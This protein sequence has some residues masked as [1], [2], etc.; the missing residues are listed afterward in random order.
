MASELTSDTTDS[1]CCVSV[2][3][4]DVIDCLSPCVVAAIL[5]ETFFSSVMMGGNKVGAG[6]DSRFFL[7]QETTVRV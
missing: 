1:S 2:V 7:E 4:A 6:I 5:I 3:S